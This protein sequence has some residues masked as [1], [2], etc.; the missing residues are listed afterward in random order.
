ML[1]VKDEN[2]NLKYSETFNIIEYA[3]GGAY[4]NGIFKN[5]NDK[6]NTDGV[7]DCYR[8]VFLH[9]EK[10]IEY[11]KTHIN[12]KGKNS[13]EVYSGEVWATELIIDF[14]IEKEN[15][16]ED[17]VKLLEDLRNLLKSI[18]SRYDLDLKHIR[19]NFSGKK[20][21]HIRIP[22]VLFGG[23]TPSDKLPAHLEANCC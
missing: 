1:K 18:E 4:H 19:I 7:N 11:Y 13:V 10:I 20:G 14:D 16:Q 22:A 12:K 2:T 15:K 5:V 17:L 3:E 8:T 23:F 21:F 9:T 6:V